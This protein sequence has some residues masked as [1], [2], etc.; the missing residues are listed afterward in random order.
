MGARKT[1]ES[2]SSA[3]T[4]PGQPIVQNGSTGIRKDCEGNASLARHGVVPPNSR[5]NAQKLCENPETFVLIVTAGAL[6]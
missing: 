4:G 3:V 5:A 1:G 2:K 6:D